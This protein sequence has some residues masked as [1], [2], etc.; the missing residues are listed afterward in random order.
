[1][2]NGLAERFNRTL[3]NMIR[4]LPPREKKSWPQMLHTLAF[5]YNCT[6]HETTGFPPFYLM[7]GRIPRL[8]VDVLFKSVLREDGDAAY[9]KFVDS[10][11]RDLREAMLLVEKNTGREQKH[12]ARI[13][14]RRVKGGQIVCG[15]RVLLAN[16]GE[17]GRKKLADKWENVVYTV[18]DCD[19]KTHIFKILN[20]VTGQTKVVHRNMLL[21]VNFLPVMAEAE[22]EGV[23]LY[24]SCSV[25]G[26]CD[27]NVSSNQH[28]ECVDKTVRTEE[29]V[30]QISVEEPDRLHISPD[31]DTHSQ[32]QD[33]AVLTVG[34][35]SATNSVEVDIAVQ[36]QEIC[37][38]D[39][40]TGQAVGDIMFGPDCTTHTH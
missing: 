34:H 9:P 33:M 23:S 40:N 18:A 19:P 5:M 1:M 29:W 28:T 4:T 13:Y 36:D 26:D 38:S 24:S 30:S 25:E 21:C 2:G 20:P 15:D 14:N 32:T 7:F 8:P 37:V 22:E 12:Q 3:S 11:H 6:V 39:T 35:D 17:R 31:G 27:T 10:L 16:K